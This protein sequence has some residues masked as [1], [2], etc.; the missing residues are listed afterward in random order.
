MHAFETTKMIRS[1]ISRLAVVACIAIP[2]LACTQEPPK[3]D[4]T[5]PPRANQG[6]G[7]YEIARTPEIVAYLDTARIE[8][9]TSGTA[10]IWFRFSYATPMTVGSDTTV[11]Y[12]ATEAREELDCHERRTKQLE[13]RMETVGGIST[14]SPSA[15]STWN[16]IDTHPLGVGVF[17][18]ACRALGTPIPAK[19]GV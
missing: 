11:N 10:R 19:P 9:P 13:I 18:V 6:A 17:L 1:S 16:S 5:L 14:G 4:G 3:T 7:W 2:S 12:R 8:R 15:E